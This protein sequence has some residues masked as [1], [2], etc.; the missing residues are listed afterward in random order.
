MPVMGRAGRKKRRVSGEGSVPLEQEA[1][2]TST[3]VPMSGRTQ[4]GRSR[5]LSQGTGQLPLERS[6]WLLTCRSWYPGQ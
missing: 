6:F 5:G 1:T 4:H 3:T 2:F